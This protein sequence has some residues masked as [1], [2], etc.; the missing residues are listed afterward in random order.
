LGVYQYLL[1]WHKD[2][3]LQNP[4][5]WSAM[6]NPPL[7][8]TIQNEWKLSINERKRILLDNIFGVDIDS[9]AVEVTKLSLL[10]KVL[11]GEDDQTL[12]VQLN[13]LK[14]RVLPDLD[15][16]IK[17]GNS[18]IGGDFYATQQLG[19]LNEEEIYRINAFD[20][21]KEFSAILKNGGFDVV[22]GNPPW[23]AEIPERD[24]FYFK[25]HYFLNAGKYESYIFFI[26]KAERLL[27]HQGVFG[28]ITP[29]YWISR[30]QTKAVKKH[31]FE[32]LYPTSLIVL[33]ENV[34]SGVK[35]D[36]CIIVAMRT[37]LK[38]VQVADITKEIIS[39]KDFKN[40]TDYCQ[41]IDL[42]LWI[43]KEKYP[44]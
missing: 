25:S 43:N 12:G 35:M 34:F 5:K 14:D 7:I 37:P 32:T 21:Q 20:W 2:F 13:M 1:D 24:K 19:L 4:Q 44:F 18:L 41:Y 42:D 40:L 9:Q 33:P 15:H 29:S 10:L 23:G 38:H 8:P 11:E 22:L 39:D 6:R 28:F 17:C 26:E 31:F 27:N 36:S 3:Y 30:S 16:N